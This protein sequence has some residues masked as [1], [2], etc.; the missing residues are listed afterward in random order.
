MSVRPNPPQPAPE[1]PAELVLEVTAADVHR[2]LPRFADD[3]A[4]VR[5][6][7]RQGYDW[8]WCTLVT[9]E[10]GYNDVERDEWCATYQL[11]DGTRILPPPAGTYIC[12]LLRV[13]RWPDPRRDRRAQQ[14]PVAATVP[15]V[16]AT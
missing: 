2:H 5:A 9:L 6:A 10:V 8:G 7:R 12:P 11:P 13:E 15:A 14:K 1:F 3:N 16:A 4:L